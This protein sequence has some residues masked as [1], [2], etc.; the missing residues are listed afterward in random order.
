M[1]ANTALL[2]ALL[3]P[4]AL[5]PAAAD[6]DPAALIEKARHAALHYT[7]SLPDFICTQM[8]HRYEDPRGD[9]RWSL[10]DVLTVRLS[11]FDRREDYKLTAIDGKITLRTFD[12]IEGARTQGEFGT[13]LLLLFHPQSQAEFHWKGW[14][15]V[16]KRRAAVFSYKV[17]KLHTSYRVAFGTVTEDSPNSILAPYRGEFFMDPESGDILHA[18]QIAELP[19]NFPIK[20]S[21][22][23]IDYDFAEVGGR[24]Y[25][26]PVRA[27]TTL[28]SGR[29]K[30]RNQVDFKDYRKFQTETTITFDK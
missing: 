22:T 12:S 6:A 7:A 17:D 26:L 4:T 9:N 2:C 10:K 18:T 3:W 1:R 24:Q 23:T 19:L 30:G 21:V 13:L 28:T 29:Y 16:H 25:L 27:E 5:L 20:Q 15:S 11:Y 8:V 14:T